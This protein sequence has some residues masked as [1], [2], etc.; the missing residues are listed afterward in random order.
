MKTLQAFLLLL[1]TVFL[2]T[3]CARPTDF[4]KLVRNDE[5]KKAFESSTILPDH[6]YYYTGP[7]AK[8]D[9]IMALHNSYTLANKRNFWIK[10][11]ITEEM[12]HSWNRIIDN[13]YRVKFPYYGSRIITSDGKEAGAWYSRYDHTVV[14]SPT[15]QSIIVYTPDVPLEHQFR[16]DR[17]S[18]RSE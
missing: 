6:T 17:F 12:L 9:A 3:G 1:L 15:P 4:G 5:V 10:V 11:D 8:P 2:I 14:K 13:S 16:I 7:E 18:E